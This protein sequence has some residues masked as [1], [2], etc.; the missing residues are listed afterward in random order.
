M[1]AGYAALGR[2]ISFDGRGMGLSDRLRDR[3]LPRIEERMDDL[4]AV[5]DAA[6]AERALVVASSRA[7]SR[8]SSSPTSS[9]RP[10]DRLRSATAAGQSGSGLDLADRG[11]HRLKGVPGAWR[12]YAVA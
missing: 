6:G 3:R 4:T 12:V 7:F 2:A 8:R 11:E 9:T 10:P 1:E 5:L